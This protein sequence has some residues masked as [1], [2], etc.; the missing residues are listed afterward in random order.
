MK[1]SPRDFLTGIALATCAWSVISPSAMAQSAP[2]GP[3]Q[4]A[5]ATPTREQ[6]NPA[7][8]VAVRRRPADL[9]SAPAP[10]PC[11]LPSDPALAFTLTGVEVQGAKALSQNEVTASAA[12]LIG[13]RITPAD[14]CSVRDRIAARLF[15]KSILSRVLIPQQQIEG[16]HVVFT[17]VEAQIIQVRYHG[18]IGPVQAKV[19]AYLNHLRG[20][21]PFDLDTAQ[22]YLLLA[23][24]LPGVRAMASLS[25][26]TAENAPSGG[27]DLDI[28]L[29]REAVDE[30]AAVQDYNSKTLGRWTAVGRVDFNSFTKFGERTSLIAYSTIN[31]TSQQV[32]EGIEQARIGS[33]GLMAQGSFAFGLSHP[34]DVLAP[35]HLV[36][37]SYVGTFE[38]DDE[39]V[40]L[41][42]LKFTLGAGMD[43]VDQATD[44]EQGG[45]LSDDALRVAWVKADTGV[46][47]PIGLTLFG[48]YLSFT[49]DLDVQLRKGLHILG[50]SAANAQDLSRIQGQSDA[51]VARTVAEGTLSGRP[52]TSGMPFDLTAHVE[53]QYADRPL[54]AYEQQAI[55]NLTVGRGYDPA[56]ATGDR[57][58][59]G[60]LRL[61]VGPFGLGR[62]KAFSFA[63]YGFYD[64]ARVD[65]LALGSINVTVHSAGGG[66]ELRFPHNIRLDVAYAHPFDRPVPAA[67]SLPPDRVLVQ[68]VVVH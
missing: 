41:K 35:L 52:F 43:I 20:L 2:T 10:E 7:G 4:A 1:A 16:G 55:G 8:Q 5:Q 23:N 3:S 18:D 67:Q 37:H 32:V 11:N 59:A 21:A 65:N 64:I 14:L 63:P 30:A 53:A 51:F 57:V 48:D 45:V 19:E 6:L 49:G 29:T 12:D 56:S 40:V 39:L 33:S 46:Q 13:K 34:T 26:S 61:R 24:Q 17:V 58:I 9:F 68:L 25:H 66:V 27:L 38:L 28:T 36:G 50:A 15:R 22:R 31:N 42:R 60:E 44:F 47:R 54:L 62:R